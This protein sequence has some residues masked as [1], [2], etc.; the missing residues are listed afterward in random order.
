MRKRKQPLVLKANAKQRQA[1]SS[2]M[3]LEILG[4]FTSP[5]GM[6][7]REVAQRM[8]RSPGSL[9]YHFR[10]MEEVGLLKRVGK[11]STAKKAEALFRPAAPR[12]EF[13]TEDRSDSAIGDALKAMESAFRMALRDLEAAM[14]DG[15]ARTSG[16]HRTFF[17][18]RVHFRTNKKTLA[19]INRHLKAIGK[20]LGRESQRA[21]LP[22]D[23]DQYCS[24]TLALLPLRDREQG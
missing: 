14:R 5:G 17:A 23:A 19:E 2:P 20:I 8:G 3:R 11:R 6:S 18:A 21:K 7:I 4:Q 12:F 16:A 1:L 24:L 13:G 22:P 15:A 9:Y 10:I